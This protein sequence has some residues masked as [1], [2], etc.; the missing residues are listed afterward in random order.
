[1][2][3]LTQEGPFTAQNVRNHGLFILRINLT[4]T[5]VC[6]LL[7]AS[8]VLSIHAEYFQFHLIQSLEQYVLCFYAPHSS[9]Q[10]KLKFLIMDWMLPELINAVIVERTTLLWSKSWNKNSRTCSQCASR[11]LTMRRSL[12]H[13]DRKERDKSNFFCF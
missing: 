8:Q 2:T 5:N 13:R 4:T 1:M 11:A 3:A 6:Y 12:L 10:C 7:K 9:V